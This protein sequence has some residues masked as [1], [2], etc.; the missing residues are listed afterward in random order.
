MTKVHPL[1][2]AGRHAVWALCWLC[3]DPAFLHNATL[4]AEGSPSPP[5]HFPFLLRPGDCSARV[6]MRKMAGGVLGGRGGKGTSCVKPHPEQ[7]SL[8][9]TV[10]K[11][12]LL[13][14]ASVNCHRPGSESPSSPNRKVRGG[15]GD[16]RYELSFASRCTLARAHTASYSLLWPAARPVPDPESFLSPFISTLSRRRLPVQQGNYPHFMD[17]CVR[18]LQPRVISSEELC[19]RVTCKSL[20]HYHG[21]AV[22]QQ[23]MTKATTDTWQA[24]SPQIALC[25]K[26]QSI[27]IYL[28][29][30]CWTV[31]VI[32]KAT[33]LITKLE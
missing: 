26:A 2:Q 9:L 11:Y 10:N 5:A 27:N 23:S 3:S 31:A 28:R 33:P 14:A 20:V 15:R 25:C 12:S 19:C 18:H 7:A 21:D 32:K 6:E 22:E 30:Y 13:C 16:G 17:Y 4:P 8:H 29:I 1:G 24:L